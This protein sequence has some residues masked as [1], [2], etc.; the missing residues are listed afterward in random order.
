[1]IERSGFVDAKELKLLLPEVIEI[2][3]DGRDTAPSQ[4][5]YE[6]KKALNEIVNTDFYKAEDV[7]YEE[8]IDS[9]KRIIDSDFLPT[10]IE[11]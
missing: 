10:V 7:S 4:S 5:G 6:L 11:I 3:R 9:L 1:M 8:T 2:R